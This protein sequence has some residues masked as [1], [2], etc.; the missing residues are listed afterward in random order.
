MMLQNGIN[1][2]SLVSMIQL[3][4]ALSAWG[5]SDFK[6]VLVRELEKMGG[7]HLP[8]Q[9]GLTTSSYALDKNLKVMVNRVFESE[10]HL[11]V[12][13]GLFYTG[14]ISGCNCADD[15]T[16][17]DECAEYCEVQLDINKKTAETT[18]MLLP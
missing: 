1:S 15:P 7:E 13:V 16:P 9:E 8:L 4:A 12:S 6:A 18:V 3:N 14:V 17:V 5:S 10:T 11:Q 2:Y